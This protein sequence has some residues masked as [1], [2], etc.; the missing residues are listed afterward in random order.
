MYA[1]LAV[2]LKLTQY[3]YYKSIILQF[4]K[5]HSISDDTI[6]VNQQILTGP[7]TTII[8]QCS[9]VA[10]HSAAQSYPPLCD[11]MDCSMPAF[12]VLHHLLEFAQTH[13][14][15][16]A[17]AI[18]PPHPLSSDSPP[19]FNLSQNQNLFQWVGSSQQVAKVLELQLQHQSFQWIFRV[20]FL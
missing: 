5:K 18:Q 15:W 19:A 20:D 10:R 16:V 3:C 1:F 6:A 13:V 2:H 9:V 14:H 4:K 17:G 12:P 7:G 8:A 11:L